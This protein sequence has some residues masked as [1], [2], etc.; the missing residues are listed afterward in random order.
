MWGRTKEKQS[1]LGETVIRTEWERGRDR[2]KIG[3]MEKEGGQQKRVGRDGEERWSEGAM[4][5]WRYGAMREL[6]GRHGKMERQ[7]CKR[8]IKR[9]ERQ[10]RNSRE[11]K[12]KREER[13]EER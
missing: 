1:G 2:G 9:L 8:K 12:K 13:K 5:P 4:E 3:E 10:N 11:N 7:D 6:D